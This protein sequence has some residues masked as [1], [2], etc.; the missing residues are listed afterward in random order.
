MSQSHSTTTT[1][2]KTPHPW[3]VQ[4]LTFQKYNSVISNYS[5]IKETEE[6]DL[7]IALTHLGESTDRNIAT[8]YPYFDLI[9]GGHSHSKTNITVNKWGMENH[10]KFEFQC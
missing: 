1:T 10:N 6:A 9:I 8:N 7:Y 4:N 3:R 5:Q 2:S